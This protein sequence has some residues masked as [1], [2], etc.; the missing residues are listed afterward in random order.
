MDIQ[1]DSREKSRAIRKIIRTFDEQGVK[2]FSS[3]LLVG[4]YMSLDNPRLIIDRNG[5]CDSRKTWGW[6]IYAWQ[7]DYGL[8]LRTGL[9]DICLLRGAA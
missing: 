8:C 2:H 6:K 1:I 9:P 7:P 5:M 3:K 4:D